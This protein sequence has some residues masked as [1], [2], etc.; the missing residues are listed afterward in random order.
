MASKNTSHK[1]F[2]PSTVTRVI[3]PLHKILNKKVGYTYPTLGHFYREIEL[4]KFP[5][6][7][8]FAKGSRFNPNHGRNVY[9]QQQYETI[10]D[11]CITNRWITITDNPNR[12]G[13]FNVR[14]LPFNENQSS[15]DNTEQSNNTVSTP[16]QRGTRPA[17]NG[18]VPAI[19]Q[20]ARAETAVNTTGLSGIPLDPQ[21]QWEI[22]TIGGQPYLFAKK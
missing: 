9:S 19:S 1:G 18:V 12:N 5:F 14:V 16:T 13:W 10:V 21:Y 17:I 2:K 22:L 4:L 3:N 7:K 20:A 11:H 6:M 8:G 15:V